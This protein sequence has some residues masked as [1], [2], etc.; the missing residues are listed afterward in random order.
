MAR[1][2]DGQLSVFTDT[3]PLK[4]RDSKKLLMGAGRPRPIPRVGKGPTQ[5]VLTPSSGGGGTF[6][7]GH[8]LT[9][10]N[11]HVHILQGWPVATFGFFQDLDYFIH[12]G[13]IEL[14]RRSI[15][16]FFFNRPQMKPARPPGWR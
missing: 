10:S 12:F 7:Q 3:C 13:P 8:S 1:N 11:I 15:F 5:E 2:G 4:R 14:Q 9:F 6:S 16:F